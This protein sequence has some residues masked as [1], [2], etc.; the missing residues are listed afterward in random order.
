MA[1]RMLGVARRPVSAKPGAVS[2]EDLQLTRPLK[3]RHLD[4]PSAGE[5]KLHDLLGRDGV[6][7]GR[8]YVSGLMKPV[9]V[10]AIY[11]RP[12]TSTP[13]RG[14]KIY[15]YLLRSA[16]CRIAY[17]SRLQRSSASTP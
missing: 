17:R 10:E 2:V 5:R 6:V 15:P 9:G 7:V 13:A 11:R 1:A 16:F 3:G 4:P 14:H 12:N 8:R